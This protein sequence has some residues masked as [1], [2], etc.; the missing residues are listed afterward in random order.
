M[1]HAIPLRERAQGRWRA[2]L[3]ALGLDSRYLTRRNGPCWQ[4][5]GKDRWRF[6][7]R[8]GSGNWVCNVCGRGDGIMLVERML[9]V[10]FAEAAKLV[11]EVLPAA[12]CRV[13]KL[14]ARDKAERRT[15]MRRL[16][17][18]AVP[19]RRGDPAWLYLASRGIE[20]ED[21][22]F[23]D[24][25]RYCATTEYVWLETLPAMLARVVS[26]D[27]KRA[28][29]IQRL[30]LKPNGEKSDIP[31]PRRMMPGETPAGSHV[32][33]GKATKHLAAGEG[34][35]SALSYRALHNVTTWAT[36]GTANMEAFTAPEGVEELTAAGDNDKNFSGQAAAYRLAN[37]AMCQQHIKARVDIPPEVGDWNGVL[38]ASR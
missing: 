30:F 4:C 19:I 14:S 11:E 3:P 17:A 8:D 9:N 33:L 28:V 38:M 36:L 23:A 37:R 25:L 35:E 1:I 34:I 12:Q 5:G 2:I 26:P 21:G 20:L 22:E 10:G 16:W 24:S 13:T 27:G 6:I 18:R 29:N 15:A 7:D 31:Q 32:R